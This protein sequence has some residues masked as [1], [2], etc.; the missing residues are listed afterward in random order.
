MS[1]R[2]SRRGGRQT[3]SLWLVART[4][5]S[6]LSLLVGDFEAFVDDA[7]PRLRRALVALRGPEAGREAVAEALAYA[8]E[9]WDRVRSMENPVG[10]L[11]RVGQSR[12]RLRRQEPLTLVSPIELPDVDPR[13]PVALNGLSEHQRV[14]V[15]LVHGCGWSH[16]D[17]AEMLEVTASTVSTHA[18]RG[19]ARLREML[20]VGVDV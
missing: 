15:F 6:G 7:E 19:I 1:A 5:E 14:T 8:W 12:S 3:G 17:V 4:A 20:E 9:H 2:E 11:Y 18:Q 16:A 10:Y 13:L